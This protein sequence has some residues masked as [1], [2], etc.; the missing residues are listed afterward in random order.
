MILFKYEIKKLL[1]NKSRLI[2]LAAIFI[3][4][5]LMGLLA[6]EGTLALI[7]S[8]DYSE[9]IRL[10]SENTGKFN[11]EQLAESGPISE[12]TEAEYRK[13]NEDGF[14]MYLHRNPIQKFHNDY[15]K[16][17]K[18]VQEYWNGPEY[19]DK[20]SILGVYPIKEKL[21]ELSDKTDTYEYKYYK[22]RLDTELSLGEPVFE[23]TL[24]WNYYSLAFDPSRVGLLLLMF[25]AFIISP[26]FTQ[27]VKTDMD[28]IILCSVKGRREIV[29]AKLLCVCV[30]SAILTVIFFLGMFI[31]TYISY[32]NLDGFDAPARCFTGLEWTTLDT[33]VG[34]MAMLGVLWIILA[35]MAF[36]LAITLISAKLKNQTATFGLG[37]AMIL[38][39]ALFGFLSDGLK[40]LLGPLA[41]FNYVA[42]SSYGVVF[43]GVK[44]YNIFGMPLSYGITAF[45]VCIALSVIA[46]LLAYIA[47]RRRSV[48]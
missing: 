18:R 7:K 39:F 34:G 43:G 16:F 28:S 31:G 25:L 44:M 30:V 15:A 23:N 37:V 35:A 9:Y 26:V 2:L 6:A 8:D 13:G 11:P 47:Q 36:G 46:V 17:G 10:V 48:M 3:I 1:F 12:A 21:K 33:T 42:L 19:Q 38:T 32:G 4:C 41:D 14:Y 40:E 45:M 29:T 5:T 27:E 24:F 20:A 22:H